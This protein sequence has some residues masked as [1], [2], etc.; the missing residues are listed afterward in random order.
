MKNEHS[1]NLKVPNSP[2]ER[3]ARSSEYV[4]LDCTMSHKSLVMKTCDSCVQSIS[5]I[6]KLHTMGG[7]E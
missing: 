4:D 5:N 2:K 7:V 3:S 6:S 1:L